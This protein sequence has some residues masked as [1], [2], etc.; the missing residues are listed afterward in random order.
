M[1]ETS[2]LIR[3]YSY[4]LFQSREVHLPPAEGLCST[5]CT[6]LAW[7][8]LYSAPFWFVQ[9]R[10]THDKGGSSVF[11]QQ[12]SRIAMYRKLF[13]IFFNCLG[14]PPWLCISRMLRYDSLQILQEAFNYWIPKQLLHFRRIGSITFRFT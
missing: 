3:S 5:F 12:P 6:S 13:D 14:I 8:P 11:F 9:T 2:S 1:L 4:S 7:E 10:P